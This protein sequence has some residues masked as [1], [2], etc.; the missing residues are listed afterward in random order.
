VSAIARVLLALV[1]LYQWVPKRGNACRFLP[2]C[3]SYAEEAI[4]LHGAGR[5]SW[6]AVRRLLRCQPLHAGGLDPVPQRGEG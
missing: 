5:G 1:R 6:L 4:A 2:T 3:S